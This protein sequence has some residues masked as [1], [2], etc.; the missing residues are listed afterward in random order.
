MYR[1]DG[2][3]IIN[4]TLRSWMG[5]KP[6]QEVFHDVQVVCNQDPVTHLPVYAINQVRTQGCS[7]HESQHQRTR[8][9]QVLIPHCFPVPCVRSTQR[10]VCWLSVSCSRR[11]MS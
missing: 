5:V 10:S 6:G 1:I 7:G 8:Q 3:E 2:L 11:C 4:S 9:I